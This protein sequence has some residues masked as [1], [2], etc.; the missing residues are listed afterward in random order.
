L[1]NYPNRQNVE[2][3]FTFTEVIKLISPPKVRSRQ[4]HI[5]TKK[6][7]VVCKS[8]N[9]GWMSA[10]ENAV[11][12]IITPLISTVP[13]T[14][15]ASSIDIL[16]KWIALKV[17]VAEHNQPE[18]AV[19]P[20]ENRARFKAMLEIPPDFKIWIAKCGVGVWQ[21]AYM[22]HTATLSLTPDFMPHHKS[23]NTQSITFGIGDLLIHV[24]HSTVTDLGYD[25]SFEPKGVVIPIFPILGSINWP[26]IRSL[27][28][29]E[30]H[31]IAGTFHQGLVDLKDRWLPVPP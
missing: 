15:T 19:T 14:L 9:N 28:V 1:P 31:Y 16:S 6:I 11:I 27:S 12:P 29:T 20:T 22:R 17:M 25:C 18:D 21:S 24:F 4:G 10:L 8:C 13:H 2:K 5:W 30:A 3:V 23:K 7:R 26:P